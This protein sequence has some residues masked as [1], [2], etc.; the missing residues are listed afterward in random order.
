M[1]VL[2]IK[3]CK[4]TDDTEKRRKSNHTHLFN[5]KIKTG[6]LSSSDFVVVVSS[7]L[8]SITNEQIVNVIES[9][10]NTLMKQIVKSQRNRMAQLFLGTN[11]IETSI[12]NEPCKLSFRKMEAQDY[13][14][15]KP[16]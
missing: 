13:V 6:L 8:N 9:T 3:N 4:S 7:N 14:L 15:S 11:S 1:K 16:F 10:N 5:V 2:K 12:L